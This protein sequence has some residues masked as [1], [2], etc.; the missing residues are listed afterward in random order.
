MSPADRSVVLVVEDDPCTLELVRY[1]LA[2]AGF[3]VRTATDGIEGLAAIRDTPA[4]LIICDVMMP[5]MDGFT[6]RDQVLLDPATRRLPF[7]FLTARAEADDEIKGLKTGVDEYI[8]KPFDPLVLVARVQ[9]VLERREAHAE[10]IR[11]DP[12]TQL[13]NRRAIETE[14]ARELERLRRYPSVASL[15]FADL[16]DFKRINDAHGHAMGDLVLVEFAGL[17]CS[18]CRSTDILGRYGGE[19]FVVYL[20]ETAEAPALEVAERLLAECQEM[21]VGP[22]QIH[23]SFS[24]GIAEAPRD[25]GSFAALCS[26]ADEAM[27]AAKRQGKARAVAW[28]PGGPA[29]RRHPVSHEV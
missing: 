19:E 15:L 21:S 16:D 27:Y 12:L 10:M 20:P 3:E 22:P 14:V 13:L 23:P 1:T 28:R 11:R 5:G 29:G 24:A 2:K 7:I 4:D 6:F 18:G 26:C 9:A 8:T 17:L 25:G